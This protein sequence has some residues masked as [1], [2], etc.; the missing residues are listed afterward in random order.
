MTTFLR[1]ASFPLLPICFCL[2]W[3][4]SPAFA[5][6]AGAFIPLTPLEKRF[7]AIVEKDD[8]MGIERQQR[9]AV[10]DMVLEARMPSPVKEDY[11]ETMVVVHYPQNTGSKAVDSYL[12]RYAQAAF[13]TSAA[14]EGGNEGHSFAIQYYPV[15]TTYEVTKP[16]PRYIS[17]AFTSRSYMGG[18]HDNWNTQVQSYD[19]K[20]GRPLGWGE[21]ILPDAEAPGKPI[22]DAA[23]PKWEE[24]VHKQ[25]P[26]IQSY[27]NM[28]G[29]KKLPLDL[30]NIALTPQGLRIIYDPYAVA[31]FSEG[32]IVVEIPLKDLPGLNVN[33]ALWQTPKGKASTKTGARKEKK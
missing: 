29:K 6:A 21:L 18:A 25:R 15:F 30:Q 9:Y 8:L 4:L 33:M 14:A 23:R 32:T 5:L 31:S 11:K 10:T 22:W 27:M 13:Y 26:E 28:F 19:L 2:A 24:Y 16:S 7:H 17:V 12:K 20:T 1:K 3:T